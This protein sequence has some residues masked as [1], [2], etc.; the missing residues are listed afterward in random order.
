MLPYLSMK[1][2]SLFCFVMMI[3]PKPQCLGYAMEFIIKTF[4]MNKG[5][6]TWFGMFGPTMWNLLIIEQFFRIF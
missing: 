3:S 1:E 4:I 2:G 6:M 5:A